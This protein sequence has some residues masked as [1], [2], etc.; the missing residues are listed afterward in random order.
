MNAHVSTVSKS[1]KLFVLELLPAP[2]GKTQFVVDGL[3]L[4]TKRQSTDDF[5][6]RPGH[7]VA[8]RE[9]VNGHPWISV[10][11]ARRNDARDMVWVGKHQS[12]FTSPQVILHE[13]G[14]A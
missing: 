4:L 11:V 3:Q 1:A 10:H 8:R 5:A 12:F 2:E 7:Y 6:L 9:M 13:K 14:N